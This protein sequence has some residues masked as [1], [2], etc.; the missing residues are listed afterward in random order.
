MIYLK[1]PLVNDPGL[2]IRKHESIGRDISH[3]FR[4]INIYLSKELEPYGIGSG[5]FPFLMRLLHRDGVSQETLASMLRYDRATITRSLNKLEE[6]SYIIR[7]RDPSDK[8]AYR[9][10]LTD[11]GQR[12]RPLFFKLSEQL[13]EVLLQGFSIEEKAMFISMVERAAMNMASVNETKKAPNE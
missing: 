1:A 7:K 10:Y 5:Q 3:L 6:T 13:N 12:M 4:S 11:S 9:V 8:R 2:H